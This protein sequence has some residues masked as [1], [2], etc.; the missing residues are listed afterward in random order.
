MVRIL[1]EYERKWC[2]PENSC[3]MKDE[4][5]KHSGIFF[6]TKKKYCIRYFDKKKKEYV[7]KLVGFERSDVVKISKKWFRIVVKGILTG[8]I[9][10]WKEI[11]NVMKGL[12]NNIEKHFHTRPEFL[13]PYRINKEHYKVKRRWMEG[14]DNLNDLVKFNDDRSR[15]VLIEF[16]GG[17]AMTKT[18]RKSIKM[19]KTCL[20]VPEGL[21][22]DLHE[23]C[24]QMEM[25][26]WKINKDYHFDMMFKSLSSLKEVF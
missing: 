26:G 9:T 6:H 8:E 22:Y 10:T 18:S 13:V 12:K 20:A 21:Y 14:L 16:I 11:E 7:V 25:K 17:P 4:Y 19:K 2:L 15:G 3:K 23:L 1:P 5:G 24:M